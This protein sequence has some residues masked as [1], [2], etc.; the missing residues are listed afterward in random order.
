[1]P[2]S[3][4]TPRFMDSVDRP[5]QPR[6][7]R[8]SPTALKPLR[9]VCDPTGFNQIQTRRSCCGARPL[10]DNMVERSVRRPGKSVGPERA[11]STDLPPDVSIADVRIRLLEYKT[12]QQLTESWQW[13]CR[14]DVSWQCS[15]DHVAAADRR[16]L[17]HSSPVCSRPRR[18]RRLRPVD[19][20]SRPTCRVTLLR[21]ATS[22]SSLWVPPVTLQMLVV[23]LVH[24]RLDYG[25]GLLVGLPA[26]PTR[27]LQSVLNAAARLIYRLTTRDHA[28]VC[29]GCGFPNELS[30][31]IKLAA[32]EYKVLH[33][34]ASRTSVR[35][36]VST[37][38]QV[39]EHSVLPM[40]TASW[41]HPSNCQQSA[42]EPLRLRLHTSG[43]HCQLT[44]LRQI[45]CQLSVDCWNVFLFKQSYP[46]IIY[47]H[48]P[49]SDPCSGCTT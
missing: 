47:W 26:Y 18:L 28:S 40:P 42:A 49:V 38:C 15:P 30:R 37:T 35:W 46:D 27:R 14:N 1:M 7:Q 41:Y 9:P 36:P 48:H 23:A 12:F 8:I 45:H 32:L 44:S 3:A 11:G 4:T 25:N 13:I 34:D 17:H 19:V 22:D 39:D 43:I 33:G 2:T 5:R 21:R 29:T 10:G 16:L 20:D 31:Y 24:S 6:W